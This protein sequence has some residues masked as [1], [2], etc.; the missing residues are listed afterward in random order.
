M[1]QLPISV[2]DRSRPG[3]QS[4]VVDARQVKGCVRAATR[5]SGGALQAQVQLT[6][7]GSQLL[8]G[9]RLQHLGLQV[10]MT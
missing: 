4:S 3:Q 2:G 7:T 1:G 6:L 10:M 9:R 5:Q 8:T